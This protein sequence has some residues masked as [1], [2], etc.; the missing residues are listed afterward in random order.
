MKREDY[1]SSVAGLPLKVAEVRAL[2]PN[3]ALGEGMERV[4]ARVALAATARPGTA[5]AAAAQILGVDRAEVLA[6]DFASLV[7]VLLAEPLVVFVE[8]VRLGALIARN[9]RENETR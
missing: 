9:E 7:L 6:V 4:V 2:R 5:A 3:H 1:C 8:P